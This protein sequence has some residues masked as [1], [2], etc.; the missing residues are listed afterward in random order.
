MTALSVLTPGVA[1]WRAGKRRTAL[2]LA[3]TSFVVWGAVALAI[4]AAGRTELV[5]LAVQPAVL[6]IVLVGALLVAPAWMWL[7]VSSYRAV[8]PADP[9]SRSRLA[10]LG[11]LGLCAAVALPP[12]AIANLAYSQYDLVTSVFRDNSAAPAPSAAVPPADREQGQPLPGERRLNILLLGSDAGPGRTEARTD[13]M[14]LASIDQETGRTVLFGLPRNLEY[15][16]MPSG[17][18]QDAYPGGFSDLL[19][20]VYREGAATHPEFG[21]GAADPGAEL[22]KGTVSQILD[23]PVH[24]Y[25]MVNMDG[26]H[27]MVDALGGLDLNVA[28]RIPMGDTGGFFEPGEQQLDG[29]HALWYARSRTG[30]SDYDRMARQRCMIGALADQAD[31]MTV[32]RHYDQ[33]AD[34]AKD[35]VSTD[36]PSG[37]LQDLTGLAE[38]INPHASVQFT[39]PLIQPGAPDYNLIRATAHDTIQQ[40]EAEQEEE[41]G[42]SGSGQ[43]QESELRTC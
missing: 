39:P 13:T 31:P 10:Q 27:H 17:P 40:S 18:A 16:P 37:M 43:S 4:A 26:F 9:R 20:A 5:A 28:A 15:A 12:A 32:L 30:G 29:A 42:Q 36:I 6:M 35:N 14:V 8:R 23:L 34:V 22:L 11:V 21:E 2:V 19:N 38:K 1:H 24:N 25:A 33:V 3:T 7:V 41:S